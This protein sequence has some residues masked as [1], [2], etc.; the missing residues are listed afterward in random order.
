MLIRGVEP[1]A[2]D[3]VCVAFAVAGADGC[4]LAC[5]SGCCLPLTTFV[6]GGLAAGKYLLAAHVQPS[7]TSMLSATATIK[8]LLSFKA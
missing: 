2:A 7:S 1:N 6:L 5:G 8:F 3:T 4:A